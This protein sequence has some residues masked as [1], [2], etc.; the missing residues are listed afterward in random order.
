MSLCIKAVVLNVGSSEAHYFRLENFCGPTSLI[1]GISWS[2]LSSKMTEVLGLR[3]CFEL[4]INLD[5]KCHLS[6]DILL[7][8]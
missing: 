8:K 3:T 1:I 4:R 7:A 6:R 5:G 2:F